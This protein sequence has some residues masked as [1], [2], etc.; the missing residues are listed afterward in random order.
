MP[1]TYDTQVIGCADCNCPVPG[2]SIACEHEIDVMLQAGSTHH[3]S[4]QALILR[5]AEIGMAKRGGTPGML[6]DYPYTKAQ[7]RLLPDVRPVSLDSL[8]IQNTD[9]NMV[10]AALKLETP[11][12]RVLLAQYTPTSGFHDDVVVVQ[13]P[14]DT[15]GLPPHMRCPAYA[16]WYTLGWV[17]DLDA[18]VDD[19]NDTT[20]RQWYVEGVRR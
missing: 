13:V 5:Q 8:R 3:Y 18:I 12:F 4:A 17:P 1:W 15:D 6:R 2:R 20:W 11:Y 7:L 16:G 19:D 14:F 10:S 9:G